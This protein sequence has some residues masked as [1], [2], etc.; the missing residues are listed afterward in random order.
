MWQCSDHVLENDLTLA[1]VDRHARVRVIVLDE[2]GDRVELLLDKQ[3]VTSQTQSHVVCQSV[4]QWVY[5]IEVT[6]MEALEAE[7]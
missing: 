5:R 3:P 4:S 6:L 2:L 1:F 7:D